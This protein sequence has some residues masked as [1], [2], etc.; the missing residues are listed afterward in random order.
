MYNKIMLCGIKIPNK[1]QFFYLK[2]LLK[3]N[4]TEIQY[5]RILAKVW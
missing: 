1:K 4:D 2:N 5:I 3:C